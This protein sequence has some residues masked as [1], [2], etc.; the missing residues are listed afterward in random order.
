M[1]YT[2]HVKVQQINIQHNTII[3]FI[4]KNINNSKINLKINHKKNKKKK[5]KKKKK[6]NNKKQ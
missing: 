1:S 6:K 3:Q 2:N 4:Q 5:K